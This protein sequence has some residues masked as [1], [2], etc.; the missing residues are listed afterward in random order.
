[1]TDVVD[2]AK[3]SQMMSGIRGRHTKPELVVR[4]MLHAAGFRYRLHR[5]DLPGT[6]DLVLPKHRAVVMVHGCFWHVHEGCRFATI[7]ASNSEFWREKLARNRERDRRQLEALQ[8]LGW[9]VLV[10]W[11][12]STRTGELRDRLE[13]ELIRWLNGNEEFGELPA[14]PTDRHPS[15]VKRS[16]ANRG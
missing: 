12:C 10:V 11:E 4:R 14:T 8:S 5:R 13:P 9:R 16:R 7:P 1:M 3:R 15:S 2:P 6:P